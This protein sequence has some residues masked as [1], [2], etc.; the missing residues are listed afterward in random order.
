[1]EF[2][3]ITASV[4]AITALLFSSISCSR[5]YKVRSVDLQT[6]RGMVKKSAPESVIMPAQRISGTDTY[7][8][9]ASID[10]DDIS[11]QLENEWVTVEATDYTTPLTYTGASLTAIGLGIGLAAIIMGT[12]SYSEDGGGGIGYGVGI[13]GGLVGGGL[14]LIGLPIMITGL[15][16]DSHEADAPSPAPWPSAKS[17]RYGLSLTISLP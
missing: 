16:M 2:L 13:L 4:F 5:T 15:V 10:M 1:M 7:L 3:R 14:T 6:A 12:Q 9:W 11:P 8:R 17:A